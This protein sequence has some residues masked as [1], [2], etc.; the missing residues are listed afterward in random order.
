MP[1][2]ISKSLEKGKI[3]ENDWKDNN[4]LKTLINVCINIENGLKDII[5]INENIQKIEYQNI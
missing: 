5:L 3:I 4:N 1:N 2:K